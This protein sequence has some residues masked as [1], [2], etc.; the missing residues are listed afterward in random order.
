MDKK[1]YKN[2]LD[3]EIMVCFKLNCKIPDNNFVKI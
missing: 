3:P 1:I 2:N